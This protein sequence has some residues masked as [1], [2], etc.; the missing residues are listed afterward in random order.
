[1]SKP[2][3][4]VTHLSGTGQLGRVGACPRRCC[5]PDTPGSS[6]RA[7][8]LA[9]LLPPDDPAAAAAVV[10]RL[11]GLVDR[12][13]RGRGARTVRGRARPPHGPA[14]A[15]AGRLG[16]RPDRAALASR[17]PAAGHLPGHAAAERGAR[18]DAGPAPG[19]ARGGCG[20]LRPAHGEAGAGDAVRVDRA[21]GV[22]GPDL[23][24][25]VGGPPGRRPR[26][27]RVRGGR[28]GG[29]GGAGGRGVGAGGAVAPGGGGGRPGDVCAGRGGV[30]RCLDQRGG[31]AP[32][33]QHGDRGDSGKERRGAAD[34]L[35]RGPAQAIDA[36]EPG[37][38]PPSAVPSSA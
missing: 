3:I 26:G 5:P 8:G 36:P 6:R 2:L 10:A 13:R 16:T 22:V 21:G 32:S 35:R 23:P 7:G 24:P 9:A 25:P 28:H 33:I 18:R 17:D 27:E 38:T 30:G 11:D 29:G 4:G 34:R 15:G 31:A 20:R 1:M 37:V 14:G 19:R 12:G